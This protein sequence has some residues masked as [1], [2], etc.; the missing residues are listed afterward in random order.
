[1]QEGTSPPKVDVKRQ[2][3]ARELAQLCRLASWY[4]RRWPAICRQGVRR[5]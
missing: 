5:D 2:Q 1:M 4:W 3:A